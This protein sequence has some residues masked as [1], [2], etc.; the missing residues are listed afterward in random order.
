MMANSRLLELRPE[1]KE[2]DLFSLHGVPTSQRVDPASHNRRH[3]DMY[4]R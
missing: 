2:L 1:T 3:D 4:A